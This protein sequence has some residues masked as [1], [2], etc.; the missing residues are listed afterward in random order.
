M[1]IA[2]AA[3]LPDCAHN[4]IPPMP[5]IPCPPPI[6]CVDGVGHSSPYATV[7]INSE[8]TKASPE[9]VHVKSGQPVDFYIEGMPAG[10][11]LEIQFPATTPVQDPRRDGYHFRIFAK[12][13]TRSTAPGDK[14]TVIEHTSG[15]SFDP[16][17]IIDP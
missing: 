5:K 14:Y 4:Y 1:V 7:C 13:V 3:L 11:D 15:K 2:L 16:F 17:I 8:I 12:T 9:F 6:P 10:T